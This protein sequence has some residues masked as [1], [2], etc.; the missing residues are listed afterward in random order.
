MDLNYSD[1]QLLLKESAERF[2]KDRYDFEKRN[3]IIASKTGF[4]AGFW[5][6]MAD[7]G[8]LA[9]PFAEE[10]G[11]LGGSAVEISL[12]MEAIGRALMVEPYLTSIILAGGLVEKLG[13]EEQKAEILGGLIDGTSRPA[14]A[15]M[16]RQTGFDL[17]NIT[18]TAT[19][20][21]DG[22]A[23]SGE[24]P[25]VPGGPF[26][27]IFLVSAKLDGSVKL[28][29]VPADAAG[30]TRTE[31]RL[32]DDSRASD[33][34][35]DNVS[36]PASALL[37]AAAD[38]L[39]EIEAAYDRANAALASEAVGIM[40]ALMDATV[41]YTKERVQF[42]KPLAAFQALQH[43]MAE[44][45]V[46]CQEARGSALLATLSVDAPRAMRIRGVS[47]ARAKIGKVSRS[48]A[49]E[50]IQLHG[51]MGFSEEMP[52]GAWFRRLYAIENTFGTT[53]DHLKRYGEIIRDPAMLSGS[54]LREPV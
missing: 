16:E 20:S 48:V 50:A 11:G 47:G 40:D 37:D 24:K 19:K 23:I 17:G 22:Y 6:E 29:V 30:L 1:E 2:L 44:M 53:A 41:A 43:R 49:Q 46:K 5:S 51:A 7:L 45:A 10:N 33:L 34:V 54:L 18:A 4:D 26:A 15:H 52:I 31:V 12:I 3:K 36:V 8:W 21:A 32:V 38:T 42:G 25:L 28:F 39:F 27:D 9:L 35:L 13:S 14:L